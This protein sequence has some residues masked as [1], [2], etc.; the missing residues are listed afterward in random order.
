MSSSSV[1][2][3]R[4]PG[5]IPPSLSLA[6]SAA[7]THLTALPPEHLVLQPAHPPQPHIIVLSPPSPLAWSI[8]HLT[9]GSIS[10]IF[11]PYIFYVQPEKHLET[12]EFPQVT[13][14]LPR[15]PPNGT[16]S[17]G[18]LQTPGA[19]G[20]GQ[21]SN[22][23]LEWRAPLF[24]QFFRKYLTPVERADVI[25]VAMEAMN[26]GDMNNV[27]AASEMLNMILKYPLTEVAKVGVGGHT[28]SVSFCSVWG[29]GG[30]ALFPNQLEL[31]E[32]RVP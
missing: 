7:T 12:L 19:W 28:A 23:M 22:R 8:Q 5:F 31:R 27:I 17:D 16:L 21:P 18:S 20:G 10:A 32:S 26:S 24:F 14:M 6:I 13:E 15:L 29:E 1:N 25:M 3:A 30:L 9:K 2:P 4:E 11:L